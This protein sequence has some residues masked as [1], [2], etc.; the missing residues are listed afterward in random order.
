M[1]EPATNVAP[2]TLNTFLALTIVTALLFRFPLNLPS[3]I[4]LSFSAW[5]QLSL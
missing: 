1:D 3:S 5:L 2:I 4:N